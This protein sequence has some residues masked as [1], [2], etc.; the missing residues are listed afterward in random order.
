MRKAVGYNLVLR[1][2]DDGGDPH[3]A[4]AGGENDS[5]QT[6]PVC[7]GKDSV[8]IMRHNILLLDLSDFS[9]YRPL[10]VT[11]SNPRFRRKCSLKVRIELKTSDGRSYYQ[12]NETQVTQWERPLPPQA[13]PPYVD[14]DHDENAPPEQTEQVPF[15]AQA[16]PQTVEVVQAGHPMPAKPHQQYVYLYLTL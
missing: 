8:M 13:P 5:N 7:G 12:N 14:H 3:E 10:S 11:P 9:P 16:E 15:K 2:V 4:A 1:L 6:F